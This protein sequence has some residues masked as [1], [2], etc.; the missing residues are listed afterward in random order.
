MNTTDVEA[1]VALID[2][3]SLVKAALALNISPEGVRQRVRSLEHDL[4][5]TLLRREG[6]QWALTHKGRELERDLR[7]FLRLAAA[8]R[9]AA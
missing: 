6:R 4:K 1:V 7:E 8:I 9:N 2:H 3:G 5:A